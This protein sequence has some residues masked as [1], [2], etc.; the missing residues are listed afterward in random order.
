MLDLFPFS[1]GA[2]TPLSS[3]GAIVGRTGAAAVIS[4]AGVFVEG[5]ERGQPCP[6]IP[7]D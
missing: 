6:A 3:N 4:E 5:K 7:S 2:Q 1:H